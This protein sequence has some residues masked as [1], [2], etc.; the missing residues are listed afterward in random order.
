MNNVF[1]PTTNQRETAVAYAPLVWILYLIFINFEG[2]HCLFISNLPLSNMEMPE[3]SVV[4]PCYNQGR[5]LQDALGCFPDYFSQTRYEI[6]IVNDGSTDPTS[7][8]SLEKAETAGFRVIHQ[9]NQGLCSARNN[10]IRASRGH[11]ILPLDGDDKIDCKLISEAICIFNQHPGYDVVYCDGAYFGAKTGPWIIGEF[12]LQRLLL[13]NYFHVSAVFRKAAWERVG[14]YDEKLN[15]LGFEDW[16]FWLS[17]IKTGGKFY[18]LRKQLFEYR[19]SEGSMVSRFTADHYEKLQQYIYTKHSDYFSKK[20]LSDHLAVQ[21]KLNK[22]LWL[23]LFMKVYFPGL[24]EK[25]VKKG[26]INSANIF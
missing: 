14:G 23:K 11:L 19:I 12:N 1:L 17:V 16:D 2:G 25:L 26:K 22:L 21:F 5:F 20:Y 10:G 15:Y 3:L 18:Y 13:W 9:Q 4:I 6:I 24:L 7:I 8:D